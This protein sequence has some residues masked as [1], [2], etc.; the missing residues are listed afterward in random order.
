MRPAAVAVA[1]ALAAPLGACEEEGAPLLDV[2]GTYTAQAGTSEIGGDCHAVDATL[3]QAAFLSWVGRGDFPIGTL[4]VLQD[5]TLLEFRFEGC[6]FSGTLDPEGGYAFNGG[7]TDPESG[8]SLAVDSSGSIEVRG[9]EY[10]KVL[11]GGLTLSVDF[12]DEGGEPGADGTPDCDRTASLYA[13][14]SML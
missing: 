6:D 4:D 5:A 2:T 12:V 13:E 3:P 1:V 9:D 11:D 8:A 7:C 14:A 10:K